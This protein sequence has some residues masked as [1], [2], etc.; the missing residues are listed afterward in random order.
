MLPPLLKA[1]RP[2]QW[3]KNLFVLAPVVFGRGLAD[4]AVAGRALAAFAIFCCAASA[5]YLF[6][7]LRDREADRQHPLKKHR[8]LAA[9]TLSAG[10][11]AFA[12]VL[13]SLVTAAGAWWLGTSFLVLVGLYLLLNSL[14]SL[15]LKNVVVLDV[16][17]VSACFVLRVLA[18]A[19]AVDV[20]VSRFLIL[21][22]TFLALF[23]ILS[24]RRHELMLLGR[25][26]ASRQRH[27]LEHYSAPLLDQMMNVV[28]ASAVL[29]YALYAVAPETVEKYD[30]SLLVYT[31]PMVLFGVFRYL[32]LIYQASDVRN[33]TEA[34]IRDVP[35]VINLL[36]WG[37]AVIW[38]IYGA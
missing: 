22:T 35:F 15:G 5:V 23:L 3:S 17:V 8:P 13:L 12:A 11:A 9:G 24:K 29:S 28:T 4:P 2:S 14:Y 20:R 34:M 10:T 19:A 25:D 38:I 30:T 27:V 33:P 32:Y 6:N 31:L 36:V 37:L 21:C 26:G 7:D 1:M 18:G 16:M